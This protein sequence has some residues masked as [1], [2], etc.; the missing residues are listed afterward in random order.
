MDERDA[1]QPVDTRA[2]VWAAVQEMYAGYLAGDPARTDA[3]LAPDVTL[4]DSSERGLVHGLGELAQLRARRAGGSP[5]VDLHATDPVIDVWGDLALVRHL[6]L[7][8]GDGAGRVVRNTSLWRRDGATG[9]WLA[10]HNH[11]DVLPD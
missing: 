5:T 4:W 1:G 2:E 10:V 7:V 11:E 3:V 9:R 6:L 8:R